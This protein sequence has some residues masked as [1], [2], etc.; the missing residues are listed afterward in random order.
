MLWGVIAIAASLSTACA[1][2]VEGPSPSLATNEGDLPLEPGVICGA[3]LVTEIAL[4]GENF[5]PIV[6]DVPGGPKTALPSV[7][8][9]RSKKLDGSE[10]TPESILFSGS[11]D[12]LTNVDK[13]SWKEGSQMTLTIDQALALGEGENGA[14]PVGMFDIQVTNPNENNAQDVGVLGVVDKPTLQAPSPGI[15]CVA[16]GDRTITLSGTTILEIERAAP[17]LEVEGVDTPF[18]VTELT[19]CTNIAH[20]KV[21]AKFCETAQV[22]LAQGS[23]EPGYPSVTLKNPETAACSSEE[24]IN[25]RVVP[26]PVINRVV[27]PL[28]CVAQADRTFT[29]EGDGFLVIDDALPALTVGGEVFAVESA[30]DCEAL[31]TMG[32]SVETCK[33]L[34]FTV[35]EDA[36][37][38]GSPEVVVTNPDPAGCSASNGVA[39]TIV[40]PPTVK[41]VAPNLVCVAES[42]RSVTVS[43][44]DFLIVEGEVPRVDVGGTRI[45]ADHVVAGGCKTLTVD[46]LKVETCDTLELTLAEGG[47]SPQVADV[48]VTNPDPAGCSDTLKE[49]LAVVAPPVIVSTSEPLVCTDDSDRPLTI[50]GTGFL[51]VGDTLP[52]VTLDGN[53]ITVDGISGCMALGL[54]AGGVEECTALDVTLPQGS[55]KGGQAELAVT[56][57]DPAGCSGTNSMVLTGPPPLTLVSAVPGNVCQS[58]GQTDVVVTGT[59]FLTIDSVPFTVN[60]NGAAITPSSVTDCTTLEVEG[61][62]V[63]SCNSFTFSTDVAT[64]PPGGIPISLTN[65]DPSGCG[66]ASDMV[67]RVV[68]P[69][70][71]AA[72]NPDHVCSDKDITLTVTGTDFAL[73]AKVFANDVAATSVT[74]NSDTEL[75]ATFITGVPAGTYDLTVSNDDNRACAVTA[76]A[77]L[78]VDPTPLVFFVDP[79][80]LYSGIEIEATIFASGLKT[81]AVKVGLVDS[82]G[83]VTDLPDFDSP[84]RP[85]RILAQVPSGIPAG[86]YDVQI[87]SDL[88]CVGSLPGGVDIT[89]NLTIDLASIEPAFAP[90][91]TDTAVTIQTNDPPKQGQVGFVSTPRVYLSSTAANTTATALR[92]VVFDSAS[93]LTAV[94]PAGLTPGEYQLIVVNPSGEVGVMATNVTITATDPPEIAAVVPSSVN[95]NSDQPG[96]IVGKN[97]DPAGVS[98]SLICLAPGATSPTSRAATVSNVTATDVDVVLPSGGLASGSVCQVELTN[99]DGASFKFSA[100][101]AKEPSQNLG[102]W[103]AGSAL[104]EARR[105]LAA[106]AGRPTNTSRFIYAIGGDEGTTAGAKSS[107]E[108]APLDV[109]G[110]MGPFTPQRNILPGARSLVDAAT[111]GNFVYLT[112]GHDGVSATQSTLRAQILNP[113]SGPEILDLD[114]A[115]GDPAG[116]AGGQWFYQLA[117]TFPSTDPSNPGGES[118]GGEPFTVQLPST[119]TGIEL[120]LRWGDTPG[121]NGY[122][123]YR[124]STVDGSVDSL[125]LLTSVTCGDK[126][127]ACGVDVTC[128]YTDNAQTPTTQESLLPRG[129][130]GVWHATEALTVAREGH[131]TVA[132][133][134]PNNPNEHFLYAFGGRDDQGAYLDSYEFTTIT[135]AAN[136]GQNVI[137]W[138]AGANTI[139]VPKADLVAW[140][141]DNNDSS[142]I[143]AGEVQVFIGTGNTASS[144]SGEILSGKLD[145][146]STTGELGVLTAENGITPD[147]A[148]ASAADGSGFLYLFG[149]TRTTLRSTD[150]SSEV[151]AGPDLDNWNSL[152]GGSLVVRRAF[153]DSLQESAIFFMLG[154][155]TEADAASVSVERAVQ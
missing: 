24:T 134:N 83:V 62:T 148:A 2:E 59:G 71:I 112:G 13:L 66:E 49:S 42:E 16:Q 155:A 88:G 11:P 77:A 118:L 87:T 28:A 70:T 29:I 143:A 105:G 50:T 9:T 69:P 19:D 91:N 31:E 32:H 39:L 140:V 133:Q 38:P 72:V 129:S 40:P 15:T 82:S 76:P 125:E 103:A 6:I 141:V 137:T 74:V 73:G 93:Q 110:A 57:P 108:A 1:E 8:L 151:L 20:D 56:N 51:R 37:S 130:L 65:P 128:D 111:I 21:K 115:L 47:L 98:V 145:A 97:F 142:Q 146:G 4:H 41:D 78:L 99:P 147:V 109:F 34:V 85:N 120:T 144:R 152:G 27:A 92:A 154:G 86:A 121:A 102:A 153:A 90:T 127:C 68:P 104:T 138:S 64:L 45:E 101:S 55:L 10:S 26:P 61:L 122:R 116:L 63:E 7:L 35:A 14:L 23:V 135:P 18:D 139:G 53:A 126:V 95:N 106:V 43:G 30:G 3:Q 136:E 84:V 96:R 60:V 94:I 58:A 25:L 5:S 12:D 123:L 52:E 119:A 22:T 81:D 89:D 48:Q 33:E 17:K 54:A 79:P 117:A 36:L 131:A 113:L 46:G 107:I 44:K 114:A 80:V 67:F 100:I 132:V 124:S 75:V 149:G 150:S